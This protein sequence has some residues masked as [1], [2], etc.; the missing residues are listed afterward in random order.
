MY[1]N[2]LQSS[3]E[4]QLGRAPGDAAFADLSVLAGFTYQF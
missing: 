4:A 1:R 2:R 3:P